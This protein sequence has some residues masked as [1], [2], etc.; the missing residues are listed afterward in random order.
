MCRVELCVLCSSK[1]H[2]AA[3]VLQRHGMLGGSCCLIAAC[4][5]GQTLRCPRRLL[6]SLNIG[7]TSTGPVLC[8]PHN[9]PMHPWTSFSAITCSATLKCFK[10][11]S[12]R[13]QVSAAPGSIK[14]ADMQIRRA[15]R[16]A[17]GLPH[18]N[19]ALTQDLHVAVRL[20]PGILPELMPPCIHRG[21]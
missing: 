5:T 1:K 3:A 20:P 6:V 15:L 4:F 10:G 19:A 12:L 9:P 16:V 18:A 11:S 17:Q 2:D 8:V 13:R 14:E 7:G 21:L